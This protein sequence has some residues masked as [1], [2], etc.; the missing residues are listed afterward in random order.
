MTVNREL[1]IPSEKSSA[2]YFDC[3]HIQCIKDF[4]GDGSFTPRQ[5]VQRKLRIA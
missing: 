5:L 4:N 2:R 3:W 1:G